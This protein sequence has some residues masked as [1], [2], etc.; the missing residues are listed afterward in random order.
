MPVYPWITGNVR[1]RCV[2][3]LLGVGAG[4]E[5]LVAERPPALVE[6]GPLPGA[7]PRG[8]CHARSIPFC[9]AIAPM[10]PS[11]AEPPSRRRASR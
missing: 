1:C 5:V 11:N 10:L 3:V 7:C 2:R 4:L 8:W 9:S 6:D